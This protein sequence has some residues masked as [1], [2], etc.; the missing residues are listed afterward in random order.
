MFLMQVLNVDLIYLALAA[1]AVCMTLIF[2]SVYNATKSFRKA[3]IAALI[4]FKIIVLLLA[5]YGVDKNLFLLFFVFRGRLLCIPI[6]ASLLAILGSLAIL[7]STL[8]SEHI[9][10]HIPISEE[11]KRGLGLDVES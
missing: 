1:M 9:L 10:R 11:V 3:L 7:L 6:N 2:T 4:V 5:A 8:F